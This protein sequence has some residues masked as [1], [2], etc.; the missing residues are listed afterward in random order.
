MPAIQSQKTERFQVQ[1]R[2][3]PQASF[4]IGEETF[5]IGEETFKFR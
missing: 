1:R 3:W 4:L 2:L 5:L